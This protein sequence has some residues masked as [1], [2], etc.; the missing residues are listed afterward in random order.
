MS[1]SSGVVLTGGNN[2]AVRQSGA[3]DPVKSTRRKGRRILFIVIIFIGLGTLITVYVKV[4]STRNDDIN[5]ELWPSSGDDSEDDANDKSGNTDDEEKKKG[6]ENGSND[7]NHTSE[8]EDDED[9]ENGGDTNDTDNNGGSESETFIGEGNSENSTGSDTGATFT[10]EGN[11]EKNRDDTDSIQHNFESTGIVEDGIF[12]TLENQPLPASL[13]VFSRS[14]LAGYTDCQDLKYDLYNATSIIVNGAI[15]SHYNTETY[16]SDYSHST[17]PEVDN[18]FEEQIGNVDYSDTDSHLE[19]IDKAD[20][21]KTTPDHVFAAYGDQLIVWDAKSGN[22]LSTTHVSSLQ[23]MGVK[24]EKRDVSIKSLL[25]HDDYLVVITAHRIAL[26]IIATESSILHSKDGGT[27]LLLYNVSSIRSDGTAL[28]LLKTKDVRGIYKNARM[29]GNIAHVVT[30]SNVDTYNHLT[31]HFNRQ[32]DR[33]SG[34]NND[35][36]VKNATDYATKIIPSFISRMMD[37]LAPDADCGDHMRM[38]VLQT[39]SDASVNVTLSHVNGI[40]NGLAQIATFDVANN[41]ML[42][43][44]TP[45][46]AFLPN[47]TEAVV[48][49]SGKKLLLATRGYR[50]TEILNG[51]WRQHTY[52]RSFSLSTDGSRAKGHDYGIVSGYLINP[53]SMDI[54]DGHLRV[55]SSADSQFVCSLQGDGNNCFWELQDIP[56]RFH[57]MTILKILA[58]SERKGMKHVGFLHD[59]GDVGKYIDN[60]MFIGGRAYIASSMESL[61]FIDMS[62]HT[63]PTIRGKLDHQ[64]ISILHSFNDGNSLVIGGIDRK[65]AEL[66]QLQINL[67]NTTD[68]SNPILLSNY[69]VDRASSS[70]IQYNLHASHFLPSSQKL[71]L[72]TSIK[73]QKESSGFDGFTIFDVFQENISTSFNI[74]HIDPIKIET[75]CCKDNYL[76]PR[77]LVKESIVT[78]IKGHTIVAYDLNTKEKLWELNLDKNNTDCSDGGYWC[79]SLTLK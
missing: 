56:E 19:M 58:N 59:L 41:D 77:S 27:G 64:S 40:M 72:P 4:T 39:V 43:S 3:A 61:H 60:V 38:S 23:G 29:I 32:Q 18:Y 26:P 50:H 44:S 49:L 74:S 47:I 65:S 14:S 20:V 68:L 7:S 51:S 75:T 66:S 36:Y 79:D 5:S 37:E 11:S 48:Y 67:F 55:A 33:Y 78:T 57:Y 28:D 52:I 17:E 76:T 15:L 34:L 12:R 31:R 21:V 69:S 70:Q 2:E 30:I 10:G 53:Y 45:T 25:L 71:I 22:L 54:W 42:S 62:N 1:G 73:V 6:G 8:H 35:E 24:T 16:Y 46:S 63:V 13:P 9:E